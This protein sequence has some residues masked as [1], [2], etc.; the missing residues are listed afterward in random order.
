MVY[1]IFHTCY[2][3]CLV[4]RPHSEAKSSPLMTSYIRGAIHLLIA[5]VIFGI[6]KLAANRP[7]P[8][9]Q[10]TALFAIVILVSGFATASL[11]YMA[12]LLRR[13]WSANLRSLEH[14]GP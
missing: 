14:T 13:S 10:T 3:Y 6:Q 7:I 9:E 5:G 8:N 11:F 12:N 4:C 1:H 2:L